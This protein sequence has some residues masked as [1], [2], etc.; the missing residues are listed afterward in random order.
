MHKETRI[1]RQA[2]DTSGTLSG[3]NGLEVDVR[4]DLMELEDLI[5]GNPG[6]KFSYGILRFP[7]PLSAAL[8]RILL[9]ASRLILTGDGIQFNL[10][11]YQL[12]SFTVL[13]ASRSIAQPFT[14]AEQIAA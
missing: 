13:S 3:P 5:D 1:N 2:F 14:E 9:S 8:E 11:L 7:E 10:C 6:P 12:T 4:F